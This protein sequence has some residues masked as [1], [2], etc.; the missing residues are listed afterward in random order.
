[1]VPLRVLEERYVTVWQVVVLVS[2]SQGQ[3]SI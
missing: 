3:Q 1:M 2:L